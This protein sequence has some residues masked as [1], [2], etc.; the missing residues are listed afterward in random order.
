LPDPTSAKPERREPLQRINLR[1]DVDLIEDLK[2]AAAERGMPCQALARELL[3]SELAKL[4][5]AT[6]ANREE[7]RVRR[8]GGTGTAP[9]RRSSARDTVTPVP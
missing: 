4:I 2:A 7:E 8:K 5:A 1:M 9:S 3:E 6:E